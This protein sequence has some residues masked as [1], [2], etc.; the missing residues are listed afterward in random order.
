[1]LDQNDTKSLGDLTPDPRNARSHPERNRSLLATS[2]QEVG[3]ARSIVVD[4]DGVVLAGNATVTAAAQAGIDRVRIIDT[5][6]SELVAVRRSG[7]TPEQ[8]RRLALLDNRT[9]EL[10]EWDTGILASLAEDTDVSDL[11]EP[12]ALR[13]L[14]G[15][16]PDVTF[17]SYDETAEEKVVYVECPSCGHCFPR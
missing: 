2:L 5:D 9:A 16:A 12:D 8:K 7:L 4:E 14:L 15:E 6:G 3:A 10:A 17:P 13:E 11:W 1:M